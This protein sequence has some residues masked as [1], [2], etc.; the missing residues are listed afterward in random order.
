MFST[1]DSCGEWIS[2]TL[3]KGT[4]S[5]VSFSDVGKVPT[6]QAQQNPMGQK[7]KI[8]WGSFGLNC[9]HLPEGSILRDLGVT[10]LIII[11]GASDY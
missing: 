9:I 10:M 7:I 4:L 6:H 8:C 5:S 3:A 11:R 1:S 2:K